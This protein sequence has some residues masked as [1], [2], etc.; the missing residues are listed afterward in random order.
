MRLEPPAYKSPQNRHK[1]LKKNLNLLLIPP[2]GT[3]PPAIHYT[4][5]PEEVPL[6]RFKKQSQ[7][8]L[9]PIRSLDLNP[10]GTN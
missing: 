5:I 3:G 2:Y 8:L 9:C 1:K 6:L 7:F 10:N 4:T